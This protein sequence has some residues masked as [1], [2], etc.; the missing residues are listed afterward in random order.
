MTEKQPKS[1]VRYVVISDDQAGQRLDN[2]LFTE[3]KN[4][5][6]SRIYR[7][8]RSGEVRVNKG[9]VRQTYRLEEQDRVRIPPVHLRSQEPPVVRPGA[10]L[11]RALGDAIL[12]E[13]DDILVIDKPSGL[14]VHGGSGINLGLIEA[15]RQ[16]RPDCK[17]L[18]LVHRLDR[19]TSGCLMVAKNRRTLVEL[20]EQLQAK[21]LQKTY[22]A[23]VQGRWPKLIRRVDAPLLKNELSSGERMV[24]VHQDG[25]R[26]STLFTVQTYL[27]DATLVR[28][29]PVTGRTHQIRVHAQHQ[30]HPIAGDAKYCPDSFNSKM[31]K[32]GLRRL[33][34][35]AH[36]LTFGL[37]GDSHTVVA[38]LPGALQNVINT[39]ENKD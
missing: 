34:L 32:S 18:E 21:T 5:P 12:L 11:Q 38:P 29:Q 10:S 19:D 13:T 26:A 14:A 22:L 25:K 2:F 7:M 33:F 6:R 4:V 35:H 24:K 1:A 36:E 27:S 16:M 30:G 17:R 20:H 15:L 39:L 37:Q 31:Q 23:L 28:V 9:R 8:L 3:L